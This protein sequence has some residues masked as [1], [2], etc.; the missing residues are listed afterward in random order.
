MKRHESLAPLS[1][2]HHGALM[3]AQ[4]LKKNAPAYKGMPTD[5]AGKVLYATQF[6]NTHLIPH[7]NAEEM[8]FKK[9]KGISALLDDGIKEI[10]GEHSLLR[11]LFIQINV[12]EDMVTYLDLLGHSLYNHIRKEERELF[13]LIEKEVDETLLLSIAPLLNH[14]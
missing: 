10:I 7:F 12:Q 4:L 3:L 1:R 14:S 5:V 6:Y 2:E 9:L 13:P 11:K 8:L